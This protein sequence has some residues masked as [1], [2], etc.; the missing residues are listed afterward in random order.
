MYREYPLETPYVAAGLKV[1]H[2]RSRRYRL[3]VPART[4]GARRL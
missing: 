3:L 4:P 1:P 2:L